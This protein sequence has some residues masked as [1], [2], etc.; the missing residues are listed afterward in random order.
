VAHVVGEPQ[1][2][3]RLRH[4]AALVLLPNKQHHPAA[5]LSAVDVSLP[6]GGRFPGE[7]LAFPVGQGGAEGQAAVPGGGG[8]EALALLEGDEEDV[9]LGGFIEA[10]GGENLGSE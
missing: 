5:A 10:E 4:P 8:E 6:G 2:E 9:A 3:E 7:A 1:A